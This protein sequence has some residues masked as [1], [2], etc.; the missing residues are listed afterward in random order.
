VFLSGINERKRATEEIWEKS[1]ASYE[2]AGT[3]D[4]QRDIYEMTLHYLYQ[5]LRQPL[6]VAGGAI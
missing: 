6:S 5:P 4:F 1:C 3:W 2:E